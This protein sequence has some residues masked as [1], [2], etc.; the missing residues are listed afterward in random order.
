[1]YTNNYDRATQDTPRSELPLKMLFRGQVLS[2]VD[3]N[4]AGLMIRDRLAGCEI[5]ERL[6]FHLAFSFEAYEFLVALEGEVVRREADTSEVFFVNIGE[7][8]TKVLRDIANALENG[9][10]LEARS[11]VGV[12]RKPAAARATAPA[13]KKTERMSRPGRYAAIG[14]LMVA[15]LVATD[16]LFTGVYENL[17]RIDAGS[18][19]VTSDLVIVAAPQSGQLAL[20]AQGE[21]VARGAPLFDVAAGAD[22]RTAVASPCDCRILKVATVDGSYVRLGQT[23]VTLVPESGRRYVSALVSAADVLRLYAGAVAT[24][25]YVDGS[26]VHAAISRIP[27]AFNEDGFATT[28]HV[29]IEIDPGRPLTADAIGQPVAVRFDVFDRTPVGRLITAGRS[30]IAAL[31]DY[32]PSANASTVDAPAKVGALDTTQQ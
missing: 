20:K 5:G 26:E 32:A 24:I 31:F 28:R 9:T 19:V 18:A 3:W 12:A 25:Q 1:M 14:A 4:M 29:P 2:I 17:F 22:A 27:P 21:T 7:R 13:P 6:R 30:Q 15:G 16:F 8:Q 23:V 11:V 10:Q